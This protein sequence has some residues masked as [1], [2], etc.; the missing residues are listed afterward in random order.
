LTPESLALVHD[1]EAEAASPAERLLCAPLD[2]A[3]FLRHLEGPTPRQPFT[4]PPPPSPHPPFSQRS[5]SAVDDA[6][7]SFT[8]SDELGANTENRMHRSNA[9]EAV[10]V[11]GITVDVAAIRPL[12][13]HGSPA[14]PQ[15]GEASEAPPISPSN[16]VEPVRSLTSDFAYVLD[17]GLSQIK[18]RRAL[19]ALSKKRER[20]L[21]DQKEMFHELGALGE[22]H[23]VLSATLPQREFQ[24]VLE[25]RGRTDAL[26]DSIAALAKAHQQLE[27]DHHTALRRWH[28][29][30]SELRD[31]YR[32]AD[33]EATQYEGQRKLLLA[34]ERQLMRQ[35]RRCQLK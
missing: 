5:I 28:G 19:S 12:E 26:S 1:N 2:N 27:S 3:T 13:I 31:S 20:A 4:L 17:V 33:N 8:I 9:K 18:K 25:W 24:A 7:K 11:G 21:R 30:L 29:E 35:L 14:A 32:R 16:A 15:T 22:K 6:S 23:L 34:E 10:A